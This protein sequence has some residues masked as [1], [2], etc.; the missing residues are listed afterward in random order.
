MAI[1]V[2]EDQLSVDVAE[3]DGQHQK[4]VEM[5]NNLHDAMKVGKGKDATGDILH[6]LANYTVEH[7]GTEEKYFEQFRY[8][9][10]HLHKKEHQ[11]FVEKVTLFIN[12]FDSGKILLTM[13]IMK[14]LKEWLVN[15]IQ[16]TDKQYTNCFN[17]NGLN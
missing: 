5:I 14:F 2:W 12:D 15:H 10:A 7:F 4:L 1:I 16:G 6:G 9:A 13:D 17:S 3:I 11:D 8:P